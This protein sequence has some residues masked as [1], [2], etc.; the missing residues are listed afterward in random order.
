MK[1]FISYLVGLLIAAFVLTPG[2]LVMWSNNDCKHIYVAVEQAEVRVVYQKVSSLP[3]I[4]TVVT[5]KREGKQIVCVK[6]FYSRKQ[7]MDYGNGYIP[8]IIL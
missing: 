4:D 5:G 2:F 1:R 8:R 6:C 7:I 3:A